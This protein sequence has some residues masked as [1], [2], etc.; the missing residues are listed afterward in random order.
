MKKLLTLI[1]LSIACPGS[2]FSMQEKSYRETIFQYK[3]VTIRVVENNM[4]TIA[5]TSERYIFHNVNDKEIP[6]I[7]QT[8]KEWID[9]NNNNTSIKEI[10]YLVRTQDKNKNGKSYYDIYNENFTNVLQSKPNA[11]KTLSTT[12][13]CPYNYSEEH[14]TNISLSWRQWFK[15][16]PLYQKIVGSIMLTCTAL[17]LL[18]K[19]LE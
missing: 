12:P 17:Y 14:T 10:I 11:I 2:A 6:K 4:S 16:R 3:D 1:I 7:T 8:I 5:Q 9:N 15:S 18:G 19:S 13:S